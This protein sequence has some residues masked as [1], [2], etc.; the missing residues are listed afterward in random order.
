MEITEQDQEREERLQLVAIHV[1]HPIIGDRRLTGT[2]IIHS[3]TGDAYID[4]GHDRVITVYREHIVAVEA[5]R[6]RQK[7]RAGL[8]ASIRLRWKIAAASILAV[9]GF[10]IGLGWILL[11]HW[12]T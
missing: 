7:A 1:A 3:G 12:R 6:V 5:V 8:W 2:K 10:W 4:L 11:A 9:A